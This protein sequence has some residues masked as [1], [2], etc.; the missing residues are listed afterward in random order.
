MKKEKT[1]SMKPGKKADKKGVS[2]II[3]SVLM[4]AISIILALSVSSWLNAS[5]QERTDTL[6]GTTN[7]IVN[8]AASGLVIDSVYLDFG[9]NVSRISVRNTGKLTEKIVSAQVLNQNGQQASLNTS[10]PVNLTIGDSV[11]LT[12]GING[13]ITACS[14]FSQAKVASECASDFYKLRPTN[15]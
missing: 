7:E 13:T 12:F 8:C 10:L 14:N 11:M 2:T 3:A 15:C 6:S 1:I 9:P 4:I 5:T